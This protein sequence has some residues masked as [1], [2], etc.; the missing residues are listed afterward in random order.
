MSRRTPIQWPDRARIAVLPCVAFETWPDD[1]GRP[2]TLNRSNRAPFPANARFKKDLC[3][4]SDR[5]YGE[6]VGIFRMLDIFAEEGIKTTFFINGSTA[7]IHP[8]IIKEI[9]AAGHEIG[10]ESYIH[11]YNYMKRPEEEH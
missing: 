6:R 10:T 3:V 4:V 1:L 2:G 7:E 11:N 9:K 8:E 5:Q